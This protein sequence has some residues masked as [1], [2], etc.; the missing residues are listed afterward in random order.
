MAAQPL[1]TSIRV[2][3]NVRS[4]RQDLRH[5]SVE[6][7]TKRLRPLV[8]SVPGEEVLSGVLVRDTAVKD[9][10]SYMG[11]ASYGAGRGF[12][13][14]VGLNSTVSFAEAQENL[15]GVDFAIQIGS[16]KFLTNSADNVDRDLQGDLRNL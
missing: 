7:I 2:A 14:V 13:V 12:P 15:P 6:A 3:R 16:D 4:Q 10:S 11:Q 1:N 8:M 5:D 9:F